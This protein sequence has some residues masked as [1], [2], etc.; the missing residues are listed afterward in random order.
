MPFSTIFCI[1]KYSLYYE[2]LSNCKDL[3]QSISGTVLLSYLFIN[4]I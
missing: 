3:A 2:M 4:Q 1:H